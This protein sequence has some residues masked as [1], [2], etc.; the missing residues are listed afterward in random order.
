MVNPLAQFVCGSRALRVRAAMSKKPAYV[1][2]NEMKNNIFF[3]PLQWS[4]VNGW[5][6]I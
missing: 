3:L 5:S 4:Q 2:H 1:L 6:V